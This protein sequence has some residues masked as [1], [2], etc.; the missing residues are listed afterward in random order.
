MSHLYEVSSLISPLLTLV[1]IYEVIHILIQLSG[2]YLLG[3]QHCL[4]T[5]MMAVS[6]QTKILALMVL[7][8]YWSL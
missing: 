4:G 7:A 6:K 3:A 2:E 8:F 1:N 5:G